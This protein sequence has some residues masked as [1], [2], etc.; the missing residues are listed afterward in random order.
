MKFSETDEGKMI[1]DKS[2]VQF[3]KEILDLYGHP[4]SSYLNELINFV[5]DEAFEAG[6]KAQLKNNCSLNPCPNCTKQ[7]R[8]ETLKEVEKIV[9]KVSEQFTSHKCN[10]L[11]CRVV[12]TPYGEEVCIYPDLDEQIKFMLI[13]LRGK[14]A[15]LQAEGKKNAA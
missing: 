15:E 14:L 4:L 11:D 5:I 3:K 9:N 10:G 6:Q 12:I 13:Q 2:W 8:L 1:N 7:A